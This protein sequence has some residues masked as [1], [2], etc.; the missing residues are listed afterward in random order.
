MQDCATRRSTIVVSRITTVAIL[1][2]HSEVMCNGG[3]RY[4]KRSTTMGG[5]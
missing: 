4:V 5:Q 3:T 2:G 1:K